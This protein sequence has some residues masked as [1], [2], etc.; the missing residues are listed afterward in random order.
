M[1]V[2]KIDGDY[3]AGRNKKYSNIYNVSGMGAVGAEQ[4]VL[5]DAEKEKAYFEKFGRT[6]EIEPYDSQKYLLDVLKEIIALDDKQRSGKDIGC[7]IRN[8]AQKAIMFA[9]ELGGDK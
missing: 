6:V 8:N 3:Y 5:E 2:L 9:K 7:A 4:M 1:Y